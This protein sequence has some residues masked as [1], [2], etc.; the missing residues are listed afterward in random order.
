MNLLYI[1]MDS[2]NR[3]VL[4]CYGAGGTHTP[5]I[6]R[7]AAKGV[8][9]ERHYA[10]SLYTIP[11]RREMWT[12]SEECWWRNWGPLEPWDRPLAYEL[13]K[14]GIVSQLVT[15]LYHFC[16]WGAHSYEYDFDGYALIRGQ[17][18]DNLATRPIDPAPDWAKVLLARRPADGPIYVR[19][20]QS[21][22]HEEDFFAPRVFNAAAQWLNSDRPAG[23]WYLHVDSF[24]PHEPFHAPEPYRTM[25]T[26]DDYRRYNPWPLYGRVAEGPSALSESELSWVRAQYRGVVSMSDRWLGRVLDELDAHQLWDDTVV[27]LT[28][29]H[30]HYLGDHGWIGKPR[31]PLH[32]TMC[33]LPLIIWWPGTRSG[34]RCSTPTQT[35]DLYPT[36]LEYLTGTAPDSLLAAGTS[37]AWFLRGETGE[38]RD[39]TVTA[40]YGGRVA[41]R[42]EGWTLLRVQDPALGPL[43]EY[44]HE[45]QVRDRSWLART[46]PTDRFVVPELESGRFIPGVDMP[47][48]RFP[49]ARTWG[50]HEDVLFAPDDPGQER[51][52]IQ[53]HPKQVRRLEEI[54]RSHMLRVR[55]PAEIFAR[56]LL[57]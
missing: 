35:L 22:R 18:H 39:Y 30:G 47:V 53:D 15:D 43:Y 48:W 54:L 16:E 24:D 25:Y 10:S 13:G 1:V 52:Q 50:S 57:N 11:T 23:P 12:G 27:V 3:Q 7:L 44:T 9:F 40:E 45:L 21:F 32:D 17:E 26:S 51:N 38:Q 14:Q 2:L 6:D 28:T 4:S 55:A 29:D 19:N 46:R 5:N 31:C 37:F 49:E 34:S 20:A 42:A 33:H 8:V 36:L 41:V 56:L